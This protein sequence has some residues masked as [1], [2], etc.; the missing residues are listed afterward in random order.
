MKLAENYNQI[1]EYMLDYVENKRTD[2]AAKTLAVPSK[3][4]TDPE[5]WQREMDLIFKRLPIMVGLSVEVPEPG[6]F[7]TLA[8]LGLPLLI[9]RLA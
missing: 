3:S 4:Y 5:V 7:K 6:S 8:M 2:Q 1:V 9:S